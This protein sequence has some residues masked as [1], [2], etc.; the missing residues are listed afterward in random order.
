MYVCLYVRIY[1]SRPIYLFILFIN[2]VILIIIIIIVNVV[3]VFIILNVLTSMDRTVAKA[4][5]CG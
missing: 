4:R 1:L 3:I 2:H 5:P